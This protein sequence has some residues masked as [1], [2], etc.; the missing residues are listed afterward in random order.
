MVTGAR[1]V[2]LARTSLALIVTLLTTAPSAPRAEAP[3][4]SPDSTPPSAPPEVKTEIDHETAELA[5][6]RG[7]LEKA[8]SEHQSVAE[9]ETKILTQLNSLDSE[10]N[11]KTRLVT[12]LRRKEDR[13]SVDLTVTRSRL[14][15]EQA[16]LEERR[17]ILRHRLRN[18]YKVG[19]K[20]GLQV[21][22]GAT[23]AVDLVRRFDWLLLV[24]A[25][26][27][28]LADEIRESV[29]DVR[30][31]EDELAR[32]QEDVRAIR[33]ESE[34]EQQGL[35]RT[36]DQRGELLDSVRKEKRKK[37]QVV[38]ELE[39][40]EQQLKQLLAQLAERARTRSTPGES[41][42][43]GGTSFAAAKGR[44]LWPVKGNVSRWFGVQKD[45]RFGTSTFNG[46][47]DIEADKE[48]DVVAVHDGRADYVDWLP[49]YGQ[50]I[51]LS[52]GD[53]FFTLYAHTSKVF[54][55]VGELVEEGD[56]IASVG[57]TGSLLGDVL[58]FE[59]RKDAQPVN[60]APWPKATL[61]AEA[62]TE[63]GSRGSSPAKHPSLEPPVPR[64][65]YLTTAIDYVNSR[66]HVGTAY[67]K[68]A[69]DCIARAHRRLGFDVLFVMG[70]DE[71]STNVEKAARAEGLSPAEYCDRMEGVFRDVWR[72]LDIS[73]DDFIRTT[74]PRHRAAVNELVRRVR[75]NGWI[76][77]DKYAGLYC[78]GCEAF[79]TEKDLVDG[80][81]PNH[82]TTPRWVEEENWFFRLSAFGDRL[83]QHLQAHPEF[84]R[85]ATRKNE[86]VAFLEAGLEDISI[87]R[88]GVTWGIPFP[89]DP[90]HV[91]YVWFD[92]LTNYL[93]AVGFGTDEAKLAKWW[94]ADVHVVGKDI[95]RFHCII[96]PAMLMAADVPLPRSIFGHGFIYHS[97]T[98]MSKSLG[99][100]VNPL[101]VVDVTGADALRYFLLREIT[102]GKDGDFTWDGFIA[103]TNAD[104][105]ND[106]GNLLKRTTD[107][108]A[109][110]ALGEVCGRGRRE[111]HGLAS[112]GGDGG[113]RGDGGVRGA[114]LSGALTALWLLV[115]RANQA[116][117]ESKPWE[118]AKDTARRGELADLLAELLEAIRIVAELAE[119]AIPAKARALRRQ[120]GLA[121]SDAAPWSASCAWNPG[122]G[123]R[124]ATGEPLFPRIDRTSDGEGEAA[125]SRAVAPK[126]AA[127]AKT[128]TTK[129]AA[130]PPAASIPIDRFRDVQLVVATVIS[131]ERVEGANRLLKLTVDLGFEQ[132]QVVAG[133]AE[134]FKPEELPGRQVVVVANLSRRRSAA[135]S[136][137]G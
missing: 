1:R 76:R 4:E 39:A 41:L 125:A 129:P 73:Y 49:G 61:C 55:S 126:R 90:A 101:D 85:P 98:K 84:V 31:A 59:I 10:I 43:K 131:A 88:A 80:K 104:L 74:Q 16:K 60:P 68:I 13:L 94:P 36:R 108:A 83:L 95:T 78:D 28:R 130:A 89:D 116:I 14:D 38:A 57:D 113:A 40:S 33:L 81:C 114:D 11:L 47:I 15:A 134:H 99:N 52:H 102:W 5:R 69:A 105:A 29:A 103:R 137:R 67:E 17:S 117:Q 120:L 24:A 7:E 64:K 123:W 109:K 132:R 3:P 111:S 44:L 86:I 12:G 122:R 56:V 106:L 121:E 118:V 112:G 30:R 70:N 58:H 79:Y 25:Q 6:V 51:I 92:A 8:R 75:A 91:V 62:L 71:H 77:R 133:I 32:K 63:A 46:G 23:S 21:I 42:P 2:L 48:S 96:W 110:F 50:C 97:G 53:G 82:G 107:M 19:E 135:S 18:I 66:P 124:V 127:S 22:L 26:D 54:V 100:I 35:L 65:L 34:Q 128:S 87:S 119:P 27:R 20:P 9:R 115:R 136:P 37:Q 72:R 93:S 45:P